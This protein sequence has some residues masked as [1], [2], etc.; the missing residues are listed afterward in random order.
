MPI[1][2]IK[3]YG[4]F[5][6]N[7]KAKPV[8]LI[9]QRLCDLAANMASTMETYQGIGLA[10]PQVGV[11]RRIIVLGVNQEQSKELIAL[12]NPEIIESEGEAVAEEGCL[13]LPQIKGE[14]RRA[15]RLLLRG[16]DLQG[17]EVEMGATDLFARVIQ[18][19][20]DHLNGTLF[21]DRLDKGQKTHLLA[22]FKEAHRRRK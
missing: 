12:I 5:I 4:D 11:G 15:H 7:K 3:I 21:I 20:I 14:V 1:L 6:L 9:D 2:P 8:T 22:Q 17:K 19:E 18:H 16:W 10:A 13:S